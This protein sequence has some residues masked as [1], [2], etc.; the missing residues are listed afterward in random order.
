M[1]PVSIKTESLKFAIK[2]NGY[3]KAIYGVN[4]YFQGFLMHH[5][6][7]FCELWLH[8]EYSGQ[9][10]QGVMDGGALC[11]SPPNRRLFFTVLRLIHHSVVTCDFKAES[12]QW[13]KC[14]TQNGSPQANS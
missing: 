4:N 2:S 3:F 5:D 1:K 14:K 7:Q 12:L 10:K 6:V 8:L 13:S 9:I 11:V